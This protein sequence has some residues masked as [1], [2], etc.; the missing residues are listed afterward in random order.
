MIGIAVFPAGKTAMAGS[1]QDSHC[2][3]CSDPAN[4]DASNVL[5]LMKARASPKSVQLP[6]PPKF[7]KQTCNSRAIRGH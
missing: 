6:I 4:F 1:L 7:R 3:C 5:G 2:L